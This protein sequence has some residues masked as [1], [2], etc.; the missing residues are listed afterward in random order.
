MRLALG[1]N[2]VVLPVILVI[3]LSLFG[4]DYI[5]S[6]SFFE[7]YVVVSFEWVWGTLALCVIWPVWESLGQIWGIVKGLIGSVGGRWE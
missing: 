3:P 1:A 5:V 6:R 2:A 7:G 4:A